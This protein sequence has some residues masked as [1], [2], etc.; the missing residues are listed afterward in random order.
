MA[1]VNKHRSQLC[2]HSEVSYSELQIRTAFNSECLLNRILNNRNTSSSGN[3]KK[4]CLITTTTIDSHSITFFKR[5]HIIHFTFIGYWKTNNLELSVFL[6]PS[7]LLIIIIVPGLYFS[8]PLYSYVSC[9]LKT[10]RRRRSENLWIMK[11]SAGFTF[12]CKVLV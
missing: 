5:K 4:Q 2:L 9:I 1:N 6:L 10:R 12:I 3:Y 8:N 11:N 7:S